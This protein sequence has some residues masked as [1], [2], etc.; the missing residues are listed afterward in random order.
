[1]ALFAILIRRT[2]RGGG[3]TDSL[4]ELNRIVSDRLAEGVTL[5]E[6]AER[7][8][9]NPTTLTHQLKRKLDMTFTQYLGRMRIDKAKDLLRRTGLGIGEVARRVGV[10]DSSNFSK[11]FKKYEGVSP[12][13]YRRH[14]K[15]SR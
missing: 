8:G 2:R 13:Q 5:A 9:R 4:A 7:L 15:G 1:M 6:V 3:V 14:I 11:L 10:A 12:Q